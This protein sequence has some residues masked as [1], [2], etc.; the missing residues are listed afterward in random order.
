M[1]TPEMQETNKRFKVMCAAI[2]AW[3]LSPCETAIVASFTDF[4][5]EHNVN[6]WVTYVSGCPEVLDIA[7]EELH[8]R[9]NPDY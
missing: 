3:L 8:K 1:L 7:L 6:N 9:R 2:E 4:D 5:E